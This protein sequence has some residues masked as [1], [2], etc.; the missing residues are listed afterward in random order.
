MRMVL[1]E[2]DVQD[3]A[4][5]VQFLDQEPQRVIMPHGMHDDLFFQGGRGV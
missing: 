5:H 3:P 4:L 2:A 1:T